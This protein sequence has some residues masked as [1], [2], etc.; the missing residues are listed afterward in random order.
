MKHSPGAS[1]TIV[2]FAAAATILVGLV[3][4]ALAEQFSAQAGALPS[5]QAAPTSPGRKGRKFHL[6]PAASNTSW[7]SMP[8]LLKIMDSSFIRAIFKSR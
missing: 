6:V 7:V 3:S 5:S 1:A 2:T 4:V 8:S